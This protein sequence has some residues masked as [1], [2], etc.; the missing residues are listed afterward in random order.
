MSPSEQF[1]AILTEHTVHIAL[2]PD[3]NR[4]NDLDGTSLKL[5]TYQLGPTTH[6]IPQSPLVCA[7]W[8]PLA[9]SSNSTDCLITVTAEA[10]IRVWQLDTSDR[11][12]FDTP[13][14]AV[15]LTKL[16]DGTSCDQ[17]FTPSAFGKSRGFSADVF[18]MEATSACFGG[19][20][21]PG[22]DGWAPMT[23]WVS[24]RNGD[25]YAL[26]P[27]LPSKFRLPRI[28]MAA[29][30]THI[31]SK[32]SCIE[33][34]DLDPDEERTLRQQLEWVQKLDLDGPFLVASGSDPSLVDK[35]WVRPSIPSAIP[36]LQGPFDVDLGDDSDDLDVS[37]IH[38]ISAKV[39]FDE[40]FSGEP[41]GF[42]EELERAQ[43]NLAATV[44]C[45]TTTDATVHILLDMEGVSGQWLPKTRSGTFTVPD[46][47]SRGLLLVESLKSGQ[48]SQQATAFD[49]PMF[50]SDAASPYDLYLTSSRQVSFISLSEWA[51]RLDSEITAFASET[52]GLALRLKTIC[53]G[54]VAFQE[55]LLVANEAGADGVPSLLSAPV[56]LDNS[57]LGHMIL[58]STASRP[59]AVVFDLPDRESPLIAPTVSQNMSPAAI[60]PNVELVRAET[61]LEARHTTPRDSYEPPS[62]FYGPPTAP[63]KDLLSMNVPQRR[64][65]MFKQIRLS[66]ATLDLMSLAHRTLAI[67]TSQ[68]EGA[69]ADLFRRCERLREELGNAVKQ[70]SELSSRVQCLDD[71]KEDG[72]HGSRNFDSRLESAKERQKGLAERHEVLRRKVARAGMAGKDLSAKEISWAQEITGLAKMVGVETEEASGGDEDEQSIANNVWNDRYA[73]VSHDVVSPFHAQNSYLQQQVKQLAKELLVQAETV[74]KEQPGSD[75]RPQTNGHARSGSNASPRSTLGVPSKLQ[76][77]KIMD[78]MAMVERESAVIEAVMA[79]LDR[80]NLEIQHTRLGGCMEENE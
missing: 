43:D 75:T 61:S 15:D 34:G 45:V 69:A 10:A 37:D 80:L 39:D 36:K 17:D 79:R 64:K 8:H 63:L 74:Q 62:I 54:P 53:E 55:R 14:L 56:I 38:V 49:S 46:S 73:S 77:A 60:P 48:A 4:L 13:A 6:V 12:S 59:Y 47:N 16:I 67:Q 28:S 27:L 24:M 33:N 22:E 35:F 18:D 32:V 52:A 23:L 3:T 72:G 7:L 11:W 5:K 9:L 66:P 40:I 51:S 30:S 76:R 25:L 70:M 41:I 29:L 58:T 42:S 2:L 1:L 21:L 78:A 50:F 19:L 65:L 68:L 31:V 71:E 20:G 44:I 26:C 57:E